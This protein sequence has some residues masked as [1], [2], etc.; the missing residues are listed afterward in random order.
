M[1]AS[2]ESAVESSPWLS[3]WMHPC[4]T[5]ERILSD[6][7]RRHILL[8]ASLGG[9]SAVI[10][11]LIDAGSTAALLDGR[12]VVVTTIAAVVVGVL[13][14]YICGFFLNWSGRLLGGHA[15]P[16]QLRAVLAWG[17]VPTI[18]CLAI[19]FLIGTGLWLLDAS[20][21]TRP[22]SAAAD[23]SVAIIAAVTGAWSSVMTLLMLGRVQ[24]FGFWR[25]IVNYLAGTILI[26]ALVALMIRTFLFQPFNIPSVSM[27]P[28]L[29]VG[30]Y[31]FVSK[32]SYGY[33]RYS[34]PF[35]PPLF[36]G[37]IFASEPQRGDLV[38][39]R[40]PKNSST[41]YIKRVVGLPNDRIQMIDGVLNIN[42]TPVKRERVEDFA[43][44]DE[45]GQVSRANRWRET[46]PNGVSYATLDIQNNGFLDNTPEF[47]V[48]PAHYFVLGDNLDNSV[49]SRLMDQL[50]TVPLENLIGRVFI[51]YF[52]KQQTAGAGLSTVRFERIGMAV[53]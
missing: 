17:F 26:A 39:F 18:L 31:V 44:T 38:V 24:G 32:Y 35:S 1:N 8:L 25:T 36:S 6:N 46:L 11:F 33:S 49:D 13:N 5:I 22:S 14:V 29:L 21:V 50:G 4:S 51:I 16:V 43:W 15:S 42:G 23:Y 2:A 37:R 30:D 52:S 3:I 45:N 27:M 19:C 7:P 10:A 48:P 40:N 41:D 20:G 34:L 9:G 12:I 53:R 47:T 28:T